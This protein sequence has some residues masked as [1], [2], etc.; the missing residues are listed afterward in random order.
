MKRAKPYLIGALAMT[1]VVALAAGSLQARQTG[2]GQQPPPQQPP[3]QPGQTTPALPTQPPLNKEEE[4]AYKV[5]F[6]L[7]SVDAEALT[8]SGEEFLKKFPESRYRESVYSRL[9]QAYLNLAQ[10]DKVIAAAEK[11]LELNPDNVDVLSVMSY[12]MLRRFDPNSLDAEQKLQKAEGYA[13]RGIELLNTLT[14]PA[15]ILDEDFNRAKNEKIAMC[16]SG[17]AL[18]FF[19][20]QRY[21]DA[22]AELEQAT[23][24]V[25]QPDPSDLWLLAAIY[26]TGKRYKEAADTFGRCSEVDWPWKDRCKQS[27]D[28][29]RQ[30]A[31]QPATAPAPKP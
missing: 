26:Q 25:S 24:L 7:K 14:K 9:A 10:V 30:M 1:L 23:T 18:S 16:R 6:E 28:R 8:A 12:S 29:A 17:L 13:K 2:Q 27:A 22:T 20:R 3:P 31:A 21:A 11:A 4:D 5:F 15:H 19:H